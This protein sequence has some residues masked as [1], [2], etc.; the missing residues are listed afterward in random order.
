MTLPVTRKM[1]VDCLLWRMQQP[2]CTSRWRAA[3]QVDHVTVLLC[4]E[5][6]MPILPGQVVQFD[7]I[8]GHA[9]GGPHEYQNLR[10]I[11]YDPCHKAKSKRDVGA[12]AKV[13]R[14]TGVTGAKRKSRKIPKG[15]K[16]QGRGFQRGK[17]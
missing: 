6:G 15:Q 16:L 9:M 11:H 14:I 12:L 2:G 7:H 8:H 10:P 4:P 5:C 13:D 3:D 17:P 1:A